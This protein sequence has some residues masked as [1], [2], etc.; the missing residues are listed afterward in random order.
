MAIW[1]AMATAALGVLVAEVLEALRLYVNG[2]GPGRTHQWPHFLAIRDYVGATVIRLL[3]GSL[4]AVSMAATGL[5]CDPALA[6]IA[7]LSTIKMVEV[8]FGYSSGT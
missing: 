1:T 6:F 4:V 2:N 7:G 5:L 3:L 8:L